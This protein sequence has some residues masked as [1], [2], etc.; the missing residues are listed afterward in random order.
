MFQIEEDQPKLATVLEIVSTIA[1]V[2]SL[3]FVGFEIHNSNKQTEQNTKALQVSAYQDLIDRIV[4]LNML[5]IEES[6]TIE[7]LLGIE[8]P[9]R[10]ELEQLNGFLWIIFRHGDMAYF[11]YEQGSISEERMLSAMGPLLGRLN[12]PYV[13]KRWHESKYNF[14]SGYV[15]YIDRYLDTQQLVAQSSN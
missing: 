12:H 1:V 8:S 2:I 15:D 7:H 13:I 9:S 11:Q 6:I 3:I 10:V 5:S 14:V 4:E